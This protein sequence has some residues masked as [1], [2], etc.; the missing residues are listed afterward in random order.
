MTEAQL[1]ALKEDTEAKIR[2]IREENK[3]GLKFAQKMKIDQEKSKYKD[4]ACKRGVEFVM[5]CQ[6]DLQELLEQLSPLFDSEGTLL[7][8]K[9]EAKDHFIRFVRD[10]GIKRERANKDEREAYAIGN[11]AR[12]GWLTEKYYRSSLGVFYLRLFFLKGFFLY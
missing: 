2:A 12:Y 4:A 7:D 3:A 8:Q 11:R 9:T 1:K 5:G 6:F 10:W